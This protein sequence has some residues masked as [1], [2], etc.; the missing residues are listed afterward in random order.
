MENLHNPQCTQLSVCK[1][2]IK[3][4]SHILGKERLF[5]DRKKSTNSHKQITIYIIILLYITQ[6]F[7]YSQIYGTTSMITQYVNIQLIGKNE[8]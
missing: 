8:G 3:I 1:F 7:T 6:L 4:I 2:D 5:T